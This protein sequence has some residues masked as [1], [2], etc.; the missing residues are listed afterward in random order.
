VTVTASLSSYPSITLALSQFTV[1]IEPCVVTTVQAVQDADQGNLAAQTYLLSSTNILTYP[2]GVK[3][4]PACG[5]TPDGWLVSA[6]G[7]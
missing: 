5:Y 1:T 6:T 2:L 3:L 4:T 7:V